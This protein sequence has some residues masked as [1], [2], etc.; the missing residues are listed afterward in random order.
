MPHKDPVTPELHEAVF[1]RDRRIVSDFLAELG[2]ATLWRRDRLMTGGGTVVCPAVVIDWDE[3]GNCGGRWRIEHVKDRIRLGL[4]AA[5]D[6]AHLMALCAN[7]TE[8][9]MRGGAVWATRKENRAAQRA[10]LEQANKE[11]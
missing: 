7:H 8:D 2:I 4:R 6:L 3:F 10:Y 1:E 5:S 11:R 9:G